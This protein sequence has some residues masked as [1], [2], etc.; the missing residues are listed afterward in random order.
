MLKTGLHETPTAPQSSSS[1][2]E[3]PGS[4]TAPLSLASAHSPPFYNSTLL[5]SCSHQSAYERRSSA[6]LDHI[7]F[8]SMKC[9]HW[10]PSTNIS[11]STLTAE[12][13]L[14]ILN[15]VASI[16]PWTQRKD[17]THPGM[18]PHACDPSPR[19]TEARGFF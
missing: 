10:P 3:H 16:Q 18:G 15:L 8:P 4:L 9:L 14:V 11:A 7:V 19:K 13:L 12:G 2:S 5:Y 1:G 17:K 6:W